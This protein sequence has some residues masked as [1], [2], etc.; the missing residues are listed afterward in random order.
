MSL[1]HRSALLALFLPLETLTV[2][3]S[4]NHLSVCLSFPKY[5]CSRNQEPCLFVPCELSYR[6]WLA[7]HMASGSLSVTSVEY[8]TIPTADSTEC[9]SKRLPCYKLPHPP[10]GVQK[11][12]VSW[13]STHS[14]AGGNN[15]I[16]DIS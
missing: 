14:S 10:A 16:I 1:K 13:L 15:K 11:G 3:P 4:C 9:L 5:S 8:V 6:A 2:L 12:P 7:Q